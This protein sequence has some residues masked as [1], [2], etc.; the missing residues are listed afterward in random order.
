MR[1]IIDPQLVNQ[2]RIDKD[3]RED[4]DQ[5]VPKWVWAG[6]GVL[7]LGLAAAGA[8]WWQSHRPVPVQT[9]MATASNA[10]R[11]GSAVL[12]ATGYVTAKRQA[13]VATQIT[14]TLTQVLIEEGDVVKPGQIMARLDDTALRASLNAAQAQT[15]VT[16]A[17][18]NQLQA[19]LAQV[20]ADA[21]RTAELAG[22]GVVTKQ[23]AEQS[24]TSVATLKAQLESARKQAEASKAQLAQAKVNFDFTVVRAPFG[25]VITAKAAQV[26]EIISPLSAGG[27]FTRTGVGTIVDMDSLEIEVDVNESYIAQV[28]PNMPVESVLQAY[29]DWRIP[30]HVIAVIPTADRG[31]AT[32]KVRVG[33]DQKD[34]RIV[35]NMGV[36]VAFLQKQDKATKDANKADA[37]KPPVGVLLAPTAIVERGGDKVVFLVQDGRAVQRSV[38]TAPQAI[39]GKTLVTQGLKAGDSVI[40]TP[41]ETLRDGMA[42]VVGPSN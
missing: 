3:L 38:T 37:P 29:P 35:P 12:Q 20:E 28:Q 14:G 33:L 31:K 21:K 6:V 41:P 36:R 10:G 32:V 8:W 24:R 22:Q 5:G 2:L 25:G 17:N 18:V 19:Q 23:V 16:A 30:S 7:A 34:A 15:E 1:P 4:A 9:V 27:G 13:T 42:V 39:D 26:G 40:A 11:A